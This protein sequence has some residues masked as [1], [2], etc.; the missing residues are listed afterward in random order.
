MATRKAYGVGLVN[1]FPKFPNIVA[2]DG[3]VSNSTYSEVFRNNYPNNYFEMFIAEQNMVG[4]AL[5]LSL[6][7]KIPFVSS[8]A[9]FHSRAFDQIRSEPV[10]LI[11]I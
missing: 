1:V 2:L 7:G 9:A 10:L 11:Q 6:R 3:E 5:G 4:V 8:F